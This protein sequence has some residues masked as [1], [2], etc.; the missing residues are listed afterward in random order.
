MAVATA[1]VLHAEGYA[2]NL[3]S[4][5]QAGMGNA[6][7]A[8]KLGS[9][10][11]IYNPA[12]LSFINGSVDFSAGVTGVRSFVTYT[13]GNYEAKT[14]NPLG[15]PL[16]LYAGFKITQNL[17]AGVSLNNPAGNSIV[18]DDNWKGG[19]LVQ[20]SSLQA[21]SVQPTL[22]FKFLDDMLSVGAGAMIMFG[23]FSTSKALIPVNGLAGIGV[24]YPP[25][26]PIL[27]KYATVVPVSATLSGKA[28]TG[29]GFNV[30]L[31]FSPISQLSIGV[32]YRSKVDLKVDGG[33]TEINYASDEMKQF[34][35]GLNPAFGVV[36]PPLDKGK[37]SA[38]MPIPSNLNVGAAYHFGKSGSV[39]AEVQF[40]GWK[41]FEEL[42]LQWDEKA[43]NIKSV[44][45]KNFVNTMIYRIGAQFGV[46]PS[47][48]VRLGA[49]YDMTPVD[50]NAYY[51][52]ETPGSNK[53]ALT[54]GWS[55]RPVTGLS[56][57]FAFTYS[58]GPKTTGKFT[59]A[60]FT[61]AAPFTGDYK[62]HA[63]LPALGLSYKF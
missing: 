34:I 63:F 28:K 55:W 21:F 60:P 49:Y 48:D 14:N 39:T 37:F 26:K 2:L 7:T 3:N 57:D 41:A 53:T 35:A 5:K 50:I 18:W 1:V 56:V 42:V 25:A 51:S 23:N 44:V 22:S 54:C 36:I 15:T 19:T 4:A 8:L 46:L 16:Y 32:S 43:M 10:S 20:N 30:G 40:V 31:L 58:N 62:V 6:G 11:M 59:A 27:D 47:F 38:S 29:V 45:P 33:E 24:A 61:A 13:N 9:E 17:A 52:P 12:G